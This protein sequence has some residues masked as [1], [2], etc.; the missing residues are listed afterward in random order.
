MKK[1]I[2]FIIVILLCSSLNA[3]GQVKGLTLVLDS[4]SSVVVPDAGGIYVTDKNPLSSDF[5]LPEDD[6]LYGRLLKNGD[7][8]SGY[9][10]WIWWDL[11][12]A[13]SNTLSIKITPSDF[14][15]ETDFF[16]DRIIPELTLGDR[17]EDSSNTTILFPDETGFDIKPYHVAFSGYIP[18]TIT[19]SEFDVLNAKAQTKY[20]ADVR[21]TVEEVL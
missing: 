13:S 20:I 12:R 10:A 3:S 21:I 15:A 6:V 7:G 11:I 16:T 17:F 19:I 1:I 18:F 8:S 9:T 14:V 4:S 2:L 5:I